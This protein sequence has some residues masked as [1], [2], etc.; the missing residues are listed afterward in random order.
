MKMFNMP[1]II[2]LYYI[3]NICFSPDDEQ[4]NYDTKEFK[5][6]VHQQTK[7][8]F[9]KLKKRSIIQGPYI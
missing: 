6:I 4:E 5:Q 9:L 8:I 3:P 2:Y 1:D 7:I